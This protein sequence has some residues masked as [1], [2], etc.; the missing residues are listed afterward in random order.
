MRKVKYGV[1][2]SYTNLNGNCYEV[3]AKYLLY[4][5]KH[6]DAGNYRLCH[7][8]VTNRV[9]GKAMGHCWIEKGNTVYDYSNGL[10]VKLSMKAYYDFGNIKKVY[11][12]TADEVRK[13]LLE[14]EHWGAWDY[15]PPR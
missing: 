1:S 3:N 15:D 6:S 4:E 11:K 12:Y 2:T 10:D 14:F 9:D 13:K 5:V 8:I 7:G